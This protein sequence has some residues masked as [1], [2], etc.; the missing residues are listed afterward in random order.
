MRPWSVGDVDSFAGLGLNPR[1]LALF[2]SLLFFRECRENLE[3]REHKTN[4]EVC[5]VMLLEESA[6]HSPLI[7][8]WDRCN[9]HSALDSVPR[10][11]SIA[12]IQLLPRKKLRSL[13][14]W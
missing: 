1:S 6:I 8:V 14:W 2:C 12:E 9:S 10:R 4:L 11:L 7:A 5:V 3:A 13:K